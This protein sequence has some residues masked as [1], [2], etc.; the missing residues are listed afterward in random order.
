MPAKIFISYSHADDQFR[1]TFEKHLAILK[2]NGHVETWCDRR[3]LAGKKFKDEIDRNLESAKVI[4]FLVSADFLHSAY[5]YGIE[6]K[7]ALELHTR[8]HAVV[9]PVIVRYCDWK[10]SLFSG[11]LA[12]PTDGKPI[13]AWEDGDQAWLSVVEAIKDALNTKNQPITDMVISHQETLW[14]SVLSPTFHDWLNDTEIEFV[15]RGTSKVYLEDVFVSP[16]LKDLSSDLDD[17]VSTIKCEDVLVKDGWRIIFGDEQSGKTSLAKYF[18]KRLLQNGYVPVMI[19]GNDIN[20]SAAKELVKKAYLTQYVRDEWEEFY[21]SNRKVVIIDDYSDVRLNRKYQNKFIKAIKT[22]FPFAILLAIDSFQYVVPEIAA[23]E[24]FD[25]YEILRFGNVKRSELI[26]KWT[27]IGVKEH[28]ADNDLYHNVDTLK[29]HIDTFVKGNIVPAKPIY[30]LT[31]LQTFETLQ[32]QQVELTSYGHCF[33]YLIYRALVGA[34]IKP[35]EMESYINVLTY[36]A[37]AV[38]ENDG[39]GLNKEMLEK[40]F[41]FYETKYLSLDKRRILRDLI[42]C[43]ILCEKDGVVG[44]KYRYI[45]YFYAAKHL[46]EQLVRSDQS[47][48][49]IRRLVSLLHKEDCA[50]IVIFIT[51]HTKDEW[52]LDEIQLCMMELFHDHEEATLRSADLEFMGEFLG[53]IPKLVI[54]K[55]E[56]EEERRHFDRRKDEQDNALVEFEN[57]T[58]KLEPTDILAKINRAFKGIELVG[59]I[60]RNRYGSLERETLKQLVAQ[61]Y[62]VGLRFLQ[63]FLS[64]SDTS[65]EEVIQ[66]IEALIREN[67]RIGNEKVEKEARS[68]FLLITYGV[69]YGVLRKIASSIG[70]KEAREVYEEL[71][72]ANG[73][74]AMKLINQAIELQF[75][76]LINQKKL[77]SLAEEFKSNVVCKRIL[78]EIV[79]QYIYMYPVGYKEKQ[80]I[81][82]KLDI[83]MADQRLKGTQRALKME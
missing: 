22:D 75:Q 61:A 17:L 50:N 56:I 64:L 68:V 15:H 53:H 66:T 35:T 7:R 28:I 29:T 41:E 11:L 78:Q 18:F 34:H 67:P 23:L 20:T 82:D 77:E 5:C 2:R 13:N 59:Q 73:S 54:E 60:V 71:E 12:L 1:K 44:F 4:V 76:K 24:G 51:H 14:Q 52:V 72:A 62:G 43:R 30:L 33:Q 19:N 40:F 49:V 38:F 27:S 79:V 32:P 81:S 3:I 45:Y 16:D 69:I 10:D 9:I 63:F 37:R 26:E 74:P 6:V 55:R 58:D 70:S 65:R 46:A 25:L 39:K 80:F 83:P 21:N 36:F 47:K 48:T 8:G 57:K 42:G 31:I